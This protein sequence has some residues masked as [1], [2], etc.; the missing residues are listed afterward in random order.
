MR[1]EPATQQVVGF[2]IPNFREWHA[3]NAQDDGGF[4]VDL[5][6]AWPLTPGRDAG[7]GPED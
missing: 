3:A 4:E 2:S 5:P 7:P 1:V 6:S